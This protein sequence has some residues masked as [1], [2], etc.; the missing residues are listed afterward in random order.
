MH[1]RKEKGAEGEKEGE[2]RTEV[3]RGAKK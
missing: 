2:R 3:K 1:G